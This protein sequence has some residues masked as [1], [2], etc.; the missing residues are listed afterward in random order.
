MNDGILSFRVTNPFERPIIAAKIRPST[1]AGHGSI[2]TEVIRKWI[3]I[4]TAANTEPTERSNSRAINSRVTPSTTTPSSGK[5][6]R[7]S[8]MLRG[9]RK[10]SVQR[11]RATATMMS[12]TSA[13]IPGS[14]TVNGGVIMRRSGGVEMYHWH[15][16][17]LSA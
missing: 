12:M 16:G 15:G 8:I 5:I 1:M 11:W 4:G 17:S 13:L 6:P 9:L 3:I 7:M 2:P 14:V 10:I